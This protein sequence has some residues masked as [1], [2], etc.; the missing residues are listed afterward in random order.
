MG[1]Y[2]IFKEKM[3][4]DKEFKDDAYQIFGISSGR[5]VHDIYIVPHLAFSMMLNNN[6]E[7]KKN[8]YEIFGTNTCELLIYSRFKSFFL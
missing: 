1:A 2:N 8:I 7:F 6:E 5:V 3:E 4:N